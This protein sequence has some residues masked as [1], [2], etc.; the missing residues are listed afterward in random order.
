MVSQIA[1]LSFD[2]TQQQRTQLFLN[3]LSQQGTVDELG[4]GNIRD[5]ISDAL[6]PGH[7]VLH[8]RAKYLLFLPRDLSRLASKTVDA[9]AEEGRRAEGQ[10]IK[11]LRQRY[12]DDGLRS[13]GIIGYTTGSETKQLPS[14]SYWGLLRQLDIY[15]GTGSLWDYYR[16][17]ATYNAAHAQKSILHSEEDAEQQAMSGLWAEYPAESPKHD[18]F[19]LSPDEAEWLRERFLASDKA[20]R[21]ERSLTSWLLDKGGPD[22]DRPWVSGLAYAWNHPLADQ[23]P[24]RTAEAMWLG[25]DVDQLLFGARILYNYLCAH[26]RPDM[27]ADR[28]TLLDK[29]RTAMGQWRAQIEME[30]PRA[31]LLHELDAWAQR[32][33]A[34][35]EAAP[36]ARLRWRSTLK[37]AQ[38]WQQLVTTS[39]DLLTDD[40]AHAHIAERERTIKPGRARLLE[41]YERLRG[42]G[43]G[44]GYFR[45]KYNW[46]PAAQILCDIHSGLGTPRT[47]IIEE[48]NT[49]TK[50]AD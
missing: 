40:Q 19:T 22:S 6:F 4:T 18:G 28:D 47:K 15:R 17:L 21:D 50:E 38:R 23:F 35:I 7:T 43:G 12:K 45:F 13:R 3:A 36:A 2:Q 42:W 24:A 16:A 8:T 11:S 33:F 14:S 26:H 34:A 48:A 29:Y 30:P 46:S 37:F 41:P 49:A 1:W 27:G 31:N 5:L 39:S 20:P 10:R 44:S 25:R 9:L 32:R